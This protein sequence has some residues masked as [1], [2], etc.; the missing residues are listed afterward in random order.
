MQANGTLDSLQIVA[1]IARGVAI[2][3]VHIDLTLIMMS[4]SFRSGLGVSVSRN[5]DPSDTL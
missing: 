4:P 5:K 2:G 1:R 3:K